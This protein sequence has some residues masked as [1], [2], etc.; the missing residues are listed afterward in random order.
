MVGTTETV[1]VVDFKKPWESITADEREALAKTADERT[2]VSQLD[3]GSEENRDQLDSGV[4]LEAYI[5]AMLEVYQ[6]NLLEIVDEL[7]KFPGA[8]LIANLIVSLDCPRPAFFNPSVMDWIKDIEL[9]FCRN[10][11]ELTF[12]RLVNPTWWLPK[13]S[14]LLQLLFEIVKCKLQELVL[15]I[16]IRLIVKIC[17][18]LASAICNALAVVGDVLAS[19][20]DLV[21]G[22]DRAD[23]SLCRRC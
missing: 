14:D 9:P 5:K 17:D 2:L 7:N 13:F 11:D 22:R 19:L 20:P 16:I 1:K 21:T 8:Q 3:I 12:P 10:L 23:V 6:E 4:V 15:K 18:L